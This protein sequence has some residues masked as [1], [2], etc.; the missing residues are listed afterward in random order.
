MHDRHNYVHDQGPMRARVPG[1]TRRDRPPW[2]LRRDRVGSPCVVTGVIRVTTRFWA[3]G[4]WCRDTV[5]V[6]RSDAASLVGF[7]S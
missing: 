3:V 7:M 6:S 1:E 2:V 5:L 4:V